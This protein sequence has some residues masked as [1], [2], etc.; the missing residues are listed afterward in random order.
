MIRMFAKKPEIKEVN[1]NKKYKFMYENFIISTQHE[2]YLFLDSDGKRSDVLKFN[3]SDM[4][5]GRPN[6]EARGA[7]PLTKY[8]DLRYGLYKVTNSPWVK[9]QMEGNRVHPLHSDS[10][11]SDKKHYVACFKD[12]MLEVACSSFEEITLSNNEILNLVSHEIDQLNE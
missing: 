6:D 4:K 10:M 1:L 12:V 5:Y 9:E 7:H 11:F 3:S 2:T 8:G